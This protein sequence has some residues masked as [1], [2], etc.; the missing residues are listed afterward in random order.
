MEPLPSKEEA[1]SKQDSSLQE[2][3]KDMKELSTLPLKTNFSPQPITTEHSLLQ[4]QQ[5][6]QYAS[7][8]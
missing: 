4:K 2:S 6:H 5:E 8:R 3:T 1:L 7:I